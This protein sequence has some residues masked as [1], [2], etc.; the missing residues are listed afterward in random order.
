MYIVSISIHGLIRSGDIELGRDA[1]TGGQ[2]LYA[3]EQARALSRDDRIARVDLLTRLIDDKRVSPDYARLTEPITKKASIVRI[4]CGPKRYLPKESLWPYLDVF[5]DNAIRYIRTRP[6]APDLIYAHYADAG[7]VGAKVSAI[8]DIPLIFSAHSLGRVKKEILID[9]GAN[10]ADI[11]NIY[12]LKR[13]IEAEEETLQSASLVIASTQHEIENQYLRYDHY[14]SKRMFLVAPGVDVSRFTPPARFGWS[15]RKSAIE[16]KIDKFLAD[17]TKPM[18]LAMARPDPKKN[19][20]ALIDA[21]GSS[22]W[23]RERANLIVIAG[24]RGDLASLAR[25]ARAEIEKIFRLTDHYDLY[26]SIAYPKSHDSADVPII[27]RLAARSGGLFVNPALTEPFGLTIIEAAASGLPVIATNHGGPTDIIARLKNGLLIDPTKPDSIRAALISALEDK[28][29]RRQWAESGAKLAR[30]IYSWDA[31]VNSIIDLVEKIIAPKEADRHLSYRP[32]KRRSQ[33]DRLLICDIDG[34]LTGDDEAL[35]DLAEEL[36][37]AGPKVGFGL[38]TGRSLELT[39]EALE[40]WPIPAPDIFITSVGTEIYYGEKLIKDYGYGAHISYRWRPDAIRAALIDAP[41]LRLQSEGENREH[42][43]SYILDQKIAPKRREIAA[44]LRQKKIAVKLIFSHGA[45]LDVLP[46][47]AGKGLAMRYVAN[48]FNIPLERVM[49]VGD[50][51]NDE[52]ML[53][54]SNIGVVVGNY[55]PELNKLKKFPK[56]YYSD[57]HRAR[58]VLDAI[59]RFGFFE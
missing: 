24:S 3:L 16:K 29:R 8:L 41:G 18:I 30:E 22:D 27:Y 58:G 36:D 37:R 57:R 50:S 6:K 20:A 39:F 17:P 21:F 53:V 15:A 9:S 13:R 38:A 40:K 7:Y 26:G 31:H 43:I 32:R 45:Y 23:L 1:D 34:V 11:E 4:R 55:A 56:V 46:V 51:G 49:A 28:E 59:E 5:V 54:G 19:L 12:H 33:N 2:T 44:M 47:R 14:E 10:R 35:G 42:K 52:D 48:K 25:A